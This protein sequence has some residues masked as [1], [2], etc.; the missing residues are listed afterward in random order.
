MIEKEVMDDTTE[1]GRAPP[2]LKLL[3]VAVVAGLA[4][5]L[6]E[7]VGAIW[8][9][10]S[11]HLPRVSPDVLWMA[12]VGDAFLAVMVAVV[13]LLVRRRVA[14]LA[15][16]PVSVGIFAGLG[17]FVLTLE[18]RWIHP[19]ALAT[20]ATGA[21]AVVGRGL[22]RLDLR[23]RAVL[24]KGA[25][26][27][28][29]GSFLAALLAAGSTWWTERRAVAG[30]P[31]PP[32]GKPNVLLIILD[33]VRAKSLGLHGRDLETSSHLER[34][35]EGGVVF[36][37]AIAPAPWTLPSHASMFTGQPPSALSTGFE[38]TLDDTYPTLAEAL[39]QH[40]FATA[41]F[42]ANLL[43]ASRQFGLARGFVRYEDYPVS[44]GQ[45]VLSTAWGRGLAGWS[46]L[47]SRLGYHELLNR[48]PASDVVDSFLEWID[49]TD[50]PF[51][52]FLNLYDAHE[53]YL[54]PAPYD[55]LFHPPA[56]RGALRHTASLMG[57]SEAA[58]PEKWG[59]TEAERRLD[60]ALYEGAIAYVDDV[61]GRLFAELER[62]G[63]LD[64]TLVIVTSDH[65][66]QFG[67]HGLYR[68]IN[69]VYMPLLHVPLVIRLPGSVPH[70]RRVS[71][72]VS[73]RQIPAT[74]I[75]LLDL[76]V[77]GE[78]PGPSLVE[79][80]GTPPRAP[81]PSFSE[82]VPGVVEQDWYPVAAGPLWSL[83]WGPFHYIR[84]AEGGEELYDL[85]RDPEELTD[86]ARDPDHVELVREFRRYLDDTLR[87]RESR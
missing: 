67:E 26:A 50:R 86:L 64:R 69:S 74:V 43:Y 46:A 18:A 34:L 4:T 57:G 87:G 47:R 29:C 68:H 25:C 61:L 79:T 17:V 5:G 56:S 41:S 30:L 44:V 83:V 60:L 8:V 13:L 75:D 28:V 21:G 80:W 33:T 23:V 40:G 7:V 81:P 72:P 70:G 85:E 27:L 62:V 49:R 84:D 32:V 65:G 38:T 10:A 76:S 54:P 66:E 24:G 3:G 58:R 14:A 42:V 35:A 37:R 77:E 82:L 78:F 2:P 15:E 12:P 31:D 16:W 9:R 22:E 52:A 59:M 48:K 39:S 45:L 55:R 1:T 51:F 20:L 36:D 6:L 63:L 53:P 71:V 11:G 19:L 73:L